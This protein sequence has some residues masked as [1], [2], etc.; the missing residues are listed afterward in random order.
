MARAILATTV[1]P[2]TQTPDNNTQAN[3]N[4]IIVDNDNDGCVNDHAYKYSNAIIGNYHIN[5]CHSD[6]ESDDDVI[7]TGTDTQSGVTVGLYIKLWRSDDTVRCGG[8][9]MQSGV[10]VRWYSQV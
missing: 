6:D 5:D 7:D 3:D 10:A 4:I 8:R 2:I 1:L 9:V